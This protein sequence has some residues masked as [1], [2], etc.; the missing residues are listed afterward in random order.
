MLAWKIQPRGSFRFICERRFISRTARLS[1]SSRAGTVTKSRMSIRTFAA[2]SGVGDG[3]RSGVLQK[4]NH[5]LGDPGRLPSEMQHLGAVAASEVQRV[6]QTHLAPERRLTVVT[7][8]KPA[9]KSESSKGEKVGA[10]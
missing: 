4:L 7:L 3:G 8:P 9:A 10:P 1:A 6:V 5:Y 2:A